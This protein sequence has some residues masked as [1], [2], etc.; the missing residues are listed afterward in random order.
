MIIFTYGYIFSTKDPIIVANNGKISVGSC[1]QIE[2]QQGK[3]ENLQEAVDSY[4]TPHKKFAS[5]GCKPDARTLSEPY[6][7]DYLGTILPNTSGRYLMRVDSLV[8]L[9]SIEEYFSQ[10][11]Y[12]L[13]SDLNEVAACKSSNNELVIY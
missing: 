8:W 2:V 4:F 12:Q 3:F 1:V 7:I 10:Q 5:N 11:P 13:F 6:P 9:A